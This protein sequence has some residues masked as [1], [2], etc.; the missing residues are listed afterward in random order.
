MPKEHK[1]NGVKKAKEIY[2]SAKARYKS[3]KKTY[4]KFKKSE[5]GKT[6]A[7]WLGPSKRKGKRGRKMKEIKFPGF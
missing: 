5:E 3:A 4:E 7:K 1:Q 6:I 2:R